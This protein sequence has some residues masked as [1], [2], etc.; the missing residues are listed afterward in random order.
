MSDDGVSAVTAGGRLEETKLLFI[1]PCALA[2]LMY[3]VKSFT[4]MQ[5]NYSGF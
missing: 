1:S 5:F 4:V 3:N 2:T